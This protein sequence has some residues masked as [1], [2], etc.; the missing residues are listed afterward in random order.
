MLQVVQIREVLHCDHSNVAAPAGAG[1]ICVAGIMCVDAVAAFHVWCYGTCWSS[2]TEA[3][4][5]SISGWV[6]PGGRAM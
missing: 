4:E 5:L 6:L 2:L 1:I 3:Y